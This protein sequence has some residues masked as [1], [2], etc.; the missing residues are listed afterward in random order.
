MATVGN[1]W[2]VVRTL[3]V[4]GGFTPD[5]DWEET[6]DIAGWRASNPFHFVSDYSKSG[7][8]RI[9][10]VASFFN[11][12]SINVLPRNNTR[13]DIQTIELMQV[14]GLPERLVS[15]RADKQL[16]GDTITSTDEH[17]LFPSQVAIRVVAAVNLPVADNIA[18]VM[19][20]V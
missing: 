3:D 19:R 20:I 4:S 12:P 15:V 13:V 17:L 6:N 8:G 16:A 11:T 14:E 9:E 1:D 10:I 18:I 7:S 2:T 5:P